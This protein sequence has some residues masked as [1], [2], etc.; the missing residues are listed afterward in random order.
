[1]GVLGVRQLGL[2]T[3][4]IRGRESLELKTFSR[5]GRW[6]ITSRGVTSN[7]SMVVVVDLPGGQQPLRAS[8]T[9]AGSAKR[10]HCS[11]AQ[12]GMNSPDARGTCQGDERPGAATRMADE[13][14]VASPPATI[15]TTPYPGT[16][17]MS[18]TQRYAR[19]KPNPNRPSSLRRLCLSCYEYMQHNM[20]LNLNWN[21][22][23]MIGAA[24]TPS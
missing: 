24:M 16:L 13:P 3:A 21:R 15:P 23:E 20:T 19:T 14:S 9:Q 18:G 4:G 1:M 11:A 22:Q 7:I 12:G 5:W 6:G 10:Q 2:P 8:A 17:K